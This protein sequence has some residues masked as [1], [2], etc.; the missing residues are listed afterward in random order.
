M[1]FLCG[2]LLYWL[3]QV[4]VRHEAAVRTRHVTGTNNLL[5]FKTWEEA[6]EAYT[7]AFFARRLRITGKVVTGRRL[8]IENIQFD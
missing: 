3:I 5:T 4:V 1:V 2:H 6:V 8:A 7:G